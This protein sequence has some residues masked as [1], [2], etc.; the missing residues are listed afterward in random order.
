MAMFS[1]AFDNANIADWM[2]YLQ[3]LPSFGESA[4]KNSHQTPEQLKEHFE[5]I[6]QE[7]L[8]VTAET[9]VKISLGKTTEDAFAYWWKQIC[10]KL[11]DLVKQDDLSRVL[12]H[13]IA[14]VIAVQ[15]TNK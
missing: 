12:L 14:E 6:K 13:L 1:N 3:N 10:Q 2:I 8:T 7:V 4:K 15:A 11:K 5:H 9:I